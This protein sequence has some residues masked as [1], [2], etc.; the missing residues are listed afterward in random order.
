MTEQRLLLNLECAGLACFAEF[1]ELFAAACPPRQAADALRAVTD[2]TAKSCLRRV[3]SARAILNAGK[4]VP[5][6]ELIV[7]STSLRLSAQAR[8]KARRLLEEIRPRIEQ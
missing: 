5:A 1:F 7:E 3:V 2:Y 6:L 4:A 8:E